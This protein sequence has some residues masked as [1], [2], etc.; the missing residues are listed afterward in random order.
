VSFEE[1]FRMR[2]PKICLFFALILT[3]FVS[4]ASAQTFGGG[5]KGGVNF[6]G[7]TGHSEARGR[8]RVVFGGFFTARV[9]DLVSIQ[10]EVLYSR[11]GVKADGKFGDGTSYTLVY[12]VDVIRVPLL[13]RIGRRT[14]G[15]LVAGP[16]L[17]WVHKATG[18]FEGGGDQ[19][20][21]YADDYKDPSVAFV[22]G[23]GVRV[24]HVV[25]EGRYLRET[26]LGAGEDSKE[27]TQALTAMVGV[28][29]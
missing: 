6:T 19:S 12:D 29:F 17:G 3:G 24:S 13:A 10:P 22:I 15:F 23:G 28:E 21:N 14:G 7:V 27:H 5:V 16:V 8:T 2:I 9:A 20:E 25:I 1:Y 26:N 11:E 18:R 4:I